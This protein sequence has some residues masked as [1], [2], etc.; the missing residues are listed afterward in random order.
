MSARND[1]RTRSNNNLQTAYA[2]AVYYQR[3]ASHESCHWQC[4]KKSRVGNIL[5][6][7]PPAER[8]GPRASTFIR[9]SAIKRSLRLYGGRGSIDSAR[10]YSVSSNLKRP[11]LES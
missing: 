6:F 11:Q 5:R 2:S 10:R 3:L 8:A 9:V 4:Q 1:A 7:S